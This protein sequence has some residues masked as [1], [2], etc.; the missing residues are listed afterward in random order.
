[1]SEIA[2]LSESRC[3]ELL[4]GE[5]V[6]RVA[7]CTPDGP[8][9]F[10]VNFTIAESSVVFRTTAYSVLGTHA[11]QTRLAFEVDR[12]D[13]ERR[14]GWSVVASGPGSQVRPGPELE[15][16]VGSWNP[17]PWAGGTRPL[18]VRLRWDTLS[19]RQIG[20]F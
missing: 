18:Y 3:L 13:P 7:L 11:W 17:D 9:I 15:E 14:S 16:I 5:A 1:V 20:S 6:G 8:Q 12:I 19:G 4:G 2:I 10:P